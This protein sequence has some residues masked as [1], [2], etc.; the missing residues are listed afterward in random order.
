VS[1]QA[2]TKK[3]LTELWGPDFSELRVPN[4]SAWCRPCSLTLCVG[5][6]G[7][8]TGSSAGGVLSAALLPLHGTAQKPPALQRHDSDHKACVREDKPETAESWAAKS[9]AWSELVLPLPKC[10]SQYEGPDT[11]EKSHGYN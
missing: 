9:L 10:C 4:P 3:S 1:W 7:L 2:H 8:I 5:F 11:R 6:A